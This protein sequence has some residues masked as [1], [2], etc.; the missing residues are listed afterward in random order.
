MRTHTTRFVLVTALCSWPATA[1]AA[2]PTA[3]GLPPPSGRI[4]N[5]S[6]ESQLQQAVRTLTSDTTIM[7]APG[8]YQLTSTLY[9]NGSLRNVSIRGASGNRDDVVLAGPGMTNASYG[10]AP[11]GIWTGGGVQ[12][13]TIA[14]L[15]VRDFYFHCVILNA[16]TTA[17]R[18]YNLRLMNAGEQI[19][20]SN[21][22][23]AGGGV[24][25]G[26]VEYSIIEYPTTSRDFYT[27]GVDVLAG[28][29][30][31]I[32][33]NLFRNIRA[34][35]GQMAGPAVL[36]WR[37]TTD[38]VTE[39]N[40]FVDCQRPIAYGLEATSPPDHARG[41]IRNNFIY[42]SASQGGDAGI[43]V[44]GSP[45]T[46]VA[47]NSVL[48]SGTYP[49]SI[50][51]RFPQ[52]TGVQILNNLTDGPI[53]RRDNATAVVS[54]NYTQATAALFVAPASGDL[55]LKASATAAIDRAT[56]AGVSL[57]WDEQPRPIGAAFDI[58]ADEFSATTPPAT[59]QNLRII[60]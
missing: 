37:G 49:S 25:D 39:G 1:A 51:Y 13:I 27:N 24:D 58:G 54:G 5:V 52:A 4:V 36:M 41:V 10:A 48:L 35:I 31:M 45:D 17:P 15:T 20:K 34:P 32:R 12:N 43:V 47:H 11:H 6:T 46:V 29:R 33:N 60:R 42:R 3:P 7:I 55:H 28:R 40:T 30:W 16:G 21:P 18:L 9:V 23:P 44:F 53:M 19:V 8:T 26:V 14:N 22:N 56:A 38:S 50:E 57:D 59:P 2:D